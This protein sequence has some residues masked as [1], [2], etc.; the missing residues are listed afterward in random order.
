[1]KISVLMPIYNEKN[2][3][4]DVLKLVKGIHIDKEIILV[5]DCSTDGTRELLRSQIGNENDI[6][7]VFYHDKNRGKGAAI[8]TALSHARG[9]YV[10]VQDADLE[11]SPQDIVQMTKSAE[12]KNAGAV[13]GSRFL[14]TWR[15]TSFPHFLVNKF[16]TV[17]TNV[18]FGGKLTDMETC[19]K[20]V[21]TDVIRSLDIRAERFEFEPEVTAKLLKKG[22]SISE[23]PVSYWGRGYDEGKKIGW[24]DGVEAV[25][26]LLKLRFSGRSD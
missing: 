8:R 18:L 2:T 20:M 14:E 11:Y 25:C 15:T 10:I 13:Y 17:L 24:R 1:M 6:V 22:I 23:I 4:M 9:D 16:L 21:R 26:T 7:K 3:I 12:E 19:Y 5:D